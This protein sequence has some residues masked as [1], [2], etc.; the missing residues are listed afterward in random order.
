M[1][2]VLVLCSWIGMLRQ[3]E[4]EVVRGRRGVEKAWEVIVCRVELREE[5]R[6]ARSEKHV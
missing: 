1:R 2:G 5:I 4:S 6:I 3:S